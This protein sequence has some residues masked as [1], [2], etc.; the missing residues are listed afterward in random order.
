MKIQNNQ[1]G[2]ITDASQN[3]QQGVIT[4]QN[5]IN[6]FLSVKE[7]VGE[8]VVRFKEN[9][10]VPVSPSNPYYSLF[11]HSSFDGFQ[12]SIANEIDGHRRFEELMSS[13][14]SKIENIEAR[15]TL[16]KNIADANLKL[17]NAETTANEKFVEAKTAANE[18]FADT[19]TEADK[20]CAD[21][22]ASSLQNLLA[23]KQQAEEHTMN[24]I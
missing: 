24:V 17:T 16:T 15:N 14:A 6:K 13:E 19:K 10:A 9:F 21:A 7:P 3:N 8:S 18:K 2:V 22:K 1:Q 11:F 5:E 20:K 4:D 12:E 23:E